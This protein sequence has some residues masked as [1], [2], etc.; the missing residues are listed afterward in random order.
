MAHHDTPPATGHAH[1]GEGHHIVGL[2]TY[3]LIWLGLLALTG[4]TVALAGIHLGRWV[5]VTA[6]AIASIKSAL[7][8]GTFMHLKFEERTFRVFVGVA[9]LTLLIFIVLTFFDYAFH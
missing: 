2:G 8:L 7:V 3:V 6:L 1:G 4:L 5:I 9:L